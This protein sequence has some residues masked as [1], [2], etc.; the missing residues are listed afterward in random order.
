[1][2]N[3][4]NKCECCFQNETQSNNILDHDFHKAL[5]TTSIIFSSLLAWIDGMNTVDLYFCIHF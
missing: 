1:M 4:I 5:R 3:I 2:V